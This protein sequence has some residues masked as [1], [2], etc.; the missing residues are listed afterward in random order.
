MN[1]SDLLCLMKITYRKYVLLLGN[2]CFGLN[3]S[4]MQSCFKNHTQDNWSHKPYTGALNPWIP[5]Y[6]FF[7]SEKKLWK[8]NHI[9][10]KNIHT[11]SKYTFL[12]NA[13]SKPLV[14]FIQQNMMFD[15]KQLF[16]I[17]WWPLG[18][19]SLCSYFIIRLP[20]IILVIYILD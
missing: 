14:H 4:I 17:Y 9:C 8:Q 2:K 3:C 1:L 13:Y 5:N 15:P 6:D 18:F 10:S 19:L 11:I 12:Q 7:F 20:M 16:S